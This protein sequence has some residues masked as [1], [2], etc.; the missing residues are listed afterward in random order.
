MGKIYLLQ[1][2]QNKYY[3]CYTKYQTLDLENLKLN[4]WLRQYPVIKVLKYVKIKKDRLNFYVR[5]YMLYYGIDNVR[6]GK[7]Y[8]MKLKKKLFDG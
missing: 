4:K 7:Y 2:Q 6:G 8:R 5:S 1:L 3:V